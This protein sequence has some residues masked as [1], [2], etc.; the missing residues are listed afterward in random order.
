MD[1]H[2]R[3]RKQLCEC[4]EEFDMMMCLGNSDYIIS[5]VNDTFG[6]RFASDRITT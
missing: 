3:E 6:C 1:V 2:C 4:M 5:E